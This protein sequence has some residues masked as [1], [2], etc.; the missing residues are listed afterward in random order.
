MAYYNYNYGFKTQPKTQRQEY[1]TKEVVNELTK[2]VKQNDDNIQH[3]YTGVT[4][5]KKEIDKVQEDVDRIRSEQAWMLNE[6]FGNDGIRSNLEDLKIK[7]GQLVERRATAPM[8]RLRV[9]VR[10]GS[11]IVRV[12]K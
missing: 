6:I 3:L 5:V 10:A 9:T 12:R 2:E 1:A 4:R 7:V 11:N 8:K